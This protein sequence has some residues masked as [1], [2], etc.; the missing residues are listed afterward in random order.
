MDYSDPKMAHFSLRGRSV[1]ELR[2][3]AET[4]FERIRPEISEMTKGDLID[5]LSKIAAQN[6]RLSAELRKGAISLKP[7]FYLMRFSDG[8]KISRDVARLQLDQYLMDRASGLKNLQ[9]QLVEELKPDSVQ[10][11]LTWQASLRYWAPGFTVKQVE[12]LKIG[13]VVLSYGERKAVIVCHTL[14]ER[15]EIVKVVTK[16]FSLQLSSMI[17]TK[18][19]LNQIGGFD[20]VKRAQYV[21]PQTDA[22]TPSNITYADENLASRSLARD[23][24]NSPRSQR[25]QSFYRIP[26]AN[27]L[28]EEGVGASSDTGKLWIPKEIP[29]DSIRLYSTALLSKISGT[30]NRM[31]RRDEIEEVLSTFNFDEMPDLNSTDPLSFRESLSNLVRTL[32]IMLSRKEEERAYTI[33]FEIARY[34]APRFFNYPRLQIVDPK[35]SEV[36]FWSDRRYASPQVAL[37]GSES[38]F[39]VTSYPGRETVDTSSLSH[40]ITGAVVSIEHVLDALELVPTEQFLGIVRGCLARVSE[41]L[42]KLKAVRNV[43]FRISGNVIALDLARAYGEPRSSTVRISPSDIAEL[44]AVL[45]KHPIVAGKRPAISAKLLQLGEKCAQMSDETCATCTRDMDKLC[46]RSLVG[47][48]LKDPQILAHKGI[49]LCDMS[50]RGTVG[51]TSHRMWGFA[52]LP[53]AKQD[54]GITL[55]NKPGAVLFAQ[56]FGQIDKASY[57]TILVISPAPINQDFQERAELLCSAF[58]KELCFLDADDLGRLLIDFEEQADYDGLSMDDIYKNSRRKITARTKKTPTPKASSTPNRS[59][60]TRASR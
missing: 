34:G 21:I 17:L 13:F 33:P 24:E 59:K 3:L 10:V 5:E 38:D 44:Q 51:S 27:S 1:E 52:K 11:F 15:D 28:L 37:S 48:Y 42:P 41:Q 47:H 22:A 46:L 56:I 26:I 2:S 35:T 53:S 45:A 54:R 29:F 43:F 30:L 7:S 55:R 58:G 40:P 57:K 18:P 25:S 50:C 16:G 23:E 12:V 4:F 14:K 19:L 39:V 6:K 36:S 31:T 20:R 9:I 60:N 8:S 49:E 32:V